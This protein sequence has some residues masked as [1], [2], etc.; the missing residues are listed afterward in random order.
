MKKLFLRLTLF[1]CGICVGQ[2]TP[3]LTKIPIPP[4]PKEYSKIQLSINY[5]IAETLGGEILYQHKKNIIGFG[6]VGYIG[7][8]SAYLVITDNHYNLKNECLY[9]TYAK[10]CKRWVIGGKVGKQNNVNWDKKVLGY[11]TLGNPISYTFEKN[12]DSYTMM[13]GFYGGYLIT[14]NFRVNIGVDSFS[15]ATFG[16]TLG[17]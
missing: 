13:V 8:N 2:P 1:I 12:V 7:N 17:F 11:N 14:K 5:G 4:Q 3:P 16:I 15:T 9:L 6:Y 10:Q